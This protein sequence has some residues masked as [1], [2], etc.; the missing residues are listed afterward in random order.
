MIGFPNQG[1]DRRL[2]KELVLCSVEKRYFR[3][4]TLFTSITDMPTLE[5]S[6]TNASVDN[7]MVQMWVTCRF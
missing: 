6:V 7:E 5:L 2:L 4:K 3:I 1:Q